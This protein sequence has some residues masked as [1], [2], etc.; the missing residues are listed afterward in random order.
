MIDTKAMAY[1]NMYSVLGT[2]DF[3]DICRV[4]SDWTD[5]YNHDRYQWDLA[6]L[7]PCE[8]YRYLTTGIYPLS[9]PKPKGKS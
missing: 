3:E 2:L 5:Y 4:I 1:V 8:Y 6:K 7:A 9:V